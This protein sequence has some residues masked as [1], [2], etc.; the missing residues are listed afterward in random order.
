MLM[1]DDS[2]SAVDS[3]TEKKIIRA[4]REERRN[5]TTLIIA[6]R[7]SALRHADE[8][9]VLD[10]GRI[11]QRGTHAELLRQQDGIYA[12]LYAIQ[13]GSDRYAENGPA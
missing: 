3:V 2:V 4:V 8:I 11:V 7:I 12:R 10:E 6:H 13:G 5:E 9:V 1:L